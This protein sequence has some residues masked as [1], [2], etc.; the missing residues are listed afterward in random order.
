MAGPVARLKQ[1]TSAKLVR[2]Y[3]APW[4]LIKVGADRR[5]PSAIVQNVGCEY[6]GYSCETD[7]GYI[8]QLHRMCRRDSFDV[9]YFQH[10][11]CDTAI[12]WIV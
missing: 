4:H 9:I 2:A 11:V 10:G 5:S 12:A 3:Q 8:L 6:K 7:D 1:Y